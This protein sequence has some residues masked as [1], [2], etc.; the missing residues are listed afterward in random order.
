MYGS[1]IEVSIQK[2]KI[3]WDIMILQKLAFIQPLIT[4]G[5]GQM[6][7]SGQVTVKTAGDHLI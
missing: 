6:L 1:A 5:H 2:T 3:G 4:T 7:N